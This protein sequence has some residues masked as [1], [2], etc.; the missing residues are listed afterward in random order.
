MTSDALRAL[1]TYAELTRKV[2]AK[3]AEIRAARGGDMQCASGCHGCCEPGL[4]VPPLEAT[5]IRRHLA[6]EP[7]AAAQ[8]AELAAADPHGGTRC[9]LL[10]AEGRCAIYAA[11][12]LICRSH[13][14]PVAFRTAADGPWQLDV[15][16][17]NFK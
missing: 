3:F 5:A 14:A 16:P 11:R 17:L 9:A 13:G 4:T 7:A 8:V 2:D 12:P 10:T 1:A 6:A 15:C